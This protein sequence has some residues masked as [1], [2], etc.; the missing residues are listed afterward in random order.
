MFDPTIIH[1]QY[2]KILLFKLYCL[3]FCLTEDEE[4][5]PVDLRVASRDGCC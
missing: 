5:L 4:I 2:C 1:R 3:K